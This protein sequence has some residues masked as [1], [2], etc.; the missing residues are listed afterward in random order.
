MQVSEILESKGSRVVAVSSGTSTADIA[1]VLKNEGIGAV[2]VK[3]GQEGMIGIVSERD[4][5][6]A[7]AERGDSA[8]SLN[9]KDLMSGS[10]VTCGPESS[11]TDIMDQM[12][13]SRIRHLPVTADGSLI[14]IISVSDVVK[15]VNGELG[16]MARALGDQVVSQ[17]GWATDED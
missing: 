10:V 14:G 6:H 13:E 8:L 2:V 7:I 4:I 3:D 9:A 11:S 17:A 1:V 16:W 15:A 12:T 5:V